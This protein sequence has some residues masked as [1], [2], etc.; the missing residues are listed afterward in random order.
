MTTAHKNTAI[1]AH[2]NPTANL[3]LGSVAGRKKHL[4]KHQNLAKLLW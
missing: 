1:Q 3:V 2:K 4:H